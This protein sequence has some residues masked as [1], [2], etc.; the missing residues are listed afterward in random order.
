MS[1]GTCFTFVPGHRL[2]G[3]GVAPVTSTFVPDSLHWSL[4]SISGLLPSFTIP[5]GAFSPGRRWKLEFDLLVFDEGLKG[6]GARPKRMGKMAICR[7]PTEKGADFQIEHTSSHPIAA[8]GRIQT[9]GD[10]LDWEVTFRDRRPEAVL[11]TTVEKGSIGPS[12]ITTEINS[13]CETLIP[14][15]PLPAFAFAEMLNRVAEGNLPEKKFS[16]LDENYVVRV[17]QRMVSAGTCTVPLAGGE[18][19]LRGFHQFGE[20]LNPISWWA[21]AETG[22]PLFVTQFNCSYML[23]KIG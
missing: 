18:M 19:P 8:E 17:N 15:V 6:K 4:Q 22:L 11:R 14:G 5:K 7:T 2:W 20:A 16:F 12:G 1:L 21:H 3:E 23:A 13:R 9:R 10:I